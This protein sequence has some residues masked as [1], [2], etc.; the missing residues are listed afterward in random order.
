MLLRSLG[1]PPP[2]PAVDEMDV[3][4][5][6]R[7]AIGAVLLMLVIALTEGLGFALLRVGLRRLLRREVL[8]AVAFS[9]LAEPPVRSV[10]R[11]GRSG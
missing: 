1:L 3:L 11:T 5:G 6:T 4:L 7:Y 10:R 8:A 2:V 9:V